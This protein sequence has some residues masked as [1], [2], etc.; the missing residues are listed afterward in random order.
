[1][2]I[3]GICGITGWKIGYGTSFFTSLMIS[4]GGCCTGCWAFG[5]AGAFGIS[6][7]FAG[8]TAF[9]ASLGAVYCVGISFFTVAPVPGILIFIPGMII[10]GFDSWAFIFFNSSKLTPYFLAIVQR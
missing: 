2:S 10:F 3:S 4:F 7:C 8:I 1:M 6:F 9:G 5:C